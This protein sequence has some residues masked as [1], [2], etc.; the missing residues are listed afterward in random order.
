MSNDNIGCCIVINEDEK[1]SID[2]TIKT[3][4]TECIKNISL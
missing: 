3:N 4:I 1:I 2:N